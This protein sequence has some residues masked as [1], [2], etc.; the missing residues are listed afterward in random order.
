[1]A[2]HFSLSW[3]INKTDGSIKWFAQ[4]IKFKFHYLR[5]VERWFIVSGRFIVT[6]QN[7]L[8]AVLHSESI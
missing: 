7:N 2:M 8:K 6:G 5:G 1:M 3:T 4:T